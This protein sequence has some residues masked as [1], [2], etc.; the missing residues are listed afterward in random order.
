M[1]AVRA[2]DGAV[3]VVDAPSPTGDGVRV[4][5]RSA[6][7]CGSDLHLIAGPL[8]VSRILGHELAGTTPDGTPVAIEPLMPCGT[9]APC[10]SGAYNLCALGP[11]IVIG[12]GHDGGM[13]EEIAVPERCLVRLPSGVR[14]E[15]ACLVE[16]LAVV[17]HGLRRA[18]LRSGERVAV[19]GGGSLGLCAVAACRAAD[20]SVDLVARHDAQREAG[21]RLGAGEPADGYDLVIDAAGSASALER[22]VALCRPGA[23]LLL[24][25]S[26]WDNVLTLPGFPLCLKEIDV[27][28]ASLYSRSGASRDI[29]VAAAVLAGQAGL[30]GAIVT[31]RFPL[32]AAPEAF[33]VAADRASGAI[34]VVLE[35]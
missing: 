32:E 28:P 9:C 15:D 34:K 20:A 25:A 11:A 7:I 26:Y 3:E 14:V 18:G 17:L 13:A 24:V 4:R 31:H 27:I 33:A 30:P 35:P 10:R 29:D 22:A 2:H 6:G 5:I 23:R 12:I 8:R 16:P 1:R 21:D 19:V